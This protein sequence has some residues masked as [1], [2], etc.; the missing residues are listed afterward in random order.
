[1]RKKK[2]F[3]H[4]VV[5]LT[6]TDLGNF[7]SIMVGALVGFSPPFNVNSSTRLWVLKTDQKL[8]NKMKTR[9]KI[10]NDVLA[11]HTHTKH[12]L[13]ITLSVITSLSLTLSLSLSLILVN[14]SSFSL[15]RCGSSF[16]FIKSTLIFPLI[17]LYRPSRFTPSKIKPSPM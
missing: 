15:F 3:A 4:Q 9:K 12:L 1:M 8:T 17:G 13:K 7:Q 11:I 16:D 2:K 10:K 14:S 5:V 6:P